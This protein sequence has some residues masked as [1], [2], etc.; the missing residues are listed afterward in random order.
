MELKNYKYVAK[1][2]SGKIIKGRME[3]LN[4]TSCIKFIQTKNL[5]VVSVTEYKSLI[6]TLNNIS[7]GKLISMKQIIF[8][9]KQLGSLL[10]A[11]VKLLPALELLSLQQENKQLRKLF[12]ELYQNVYNGF[13]FSKSLANRPKDFPNLLVMM[14][15]VGEV[16]GD[17]PDTVIRMADYYSNQMKLNG[18]IVGAIRTPM[19]YLFVAL[20]IAVGML[21]FVF[22]NIT[23][24]FSA[25]GD[26]KVPGITQAFLDAGDFMI[27]Y[28]IPLFSSI[29]A[30]ILT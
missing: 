1:D 3:A 26:A 7:F 5:H 18:K 20:T 24:L 23:G 4:R 17:L 22:P 29:F 14:I 8:F 10:K 13:S 2:D 21:L 12:F 9:L 27:N 25:F 28:S 16:S 30:F 11:G 15:E 19:I 6:S